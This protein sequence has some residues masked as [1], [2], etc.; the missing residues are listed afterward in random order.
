MSD[1]PS[2]WATVKAVAAAP[3]PGSTALRAGIGAGAATLEAGSDSVSALVAAYQQ[4]VGGVRV[5][6]AEQRDWVAMLTSLENLKD[7]ACAL[8]AEL[9]V[10]VVNSEVASAHLAAKDAV[11]VDA[12]AEVRA[13]ARERRAARA[14]RSAINQVALARRES[15]HRAAILVGAARA[16]VEEMPHTLAALGSGRLNEH[17]AVLLVRETACLDRAGRAHVDQVLCADPRA[18]AGLGAKRLLALAA[19]HAYALDPASVVRRNERAETERN[20]TLRPAPGGMTYLSALLPLAQ[21]VAVLANLRGTAQ[22]AR[23][24]GDERSIGQVMADTLVERTTG[25]A[26]A[27]AV[28][29]AVNLIVS[30]ATLLGAGHEPAVLD[31]ALHLP[32]QLARELVARA[33]Q[34]DTDD[35]TCAPADRRQRAARLGAWVRRLYADPGGNLVA[36]DSR[37]RTFPTALAALLRVRDQGLCRTPF[38]D[39]PIAH[40]DHVTPAAA[41]GATSASNGQGLCAGCNYAKQAPG[42]DQRVAPRAERHSVVTTTPTGHTYV[43]TA[44]AVPTPLRPVARRPDHESGSP[45]EETFRAIIEISYC[46]PTPL[47]TGPPTARTGAPAAHTG[48]PAAHTGP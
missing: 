30:D 27:S 48:P 10:R 18:L 43:S 36:M 35:A 45:V 40:T 7:A 26:A 12:P 42:W 20:V 25:Q 38:C 17:R 14:R 24:V 39:A 3:S 28:P 1:S 47:A 41:V 8:Q 4:I 33:M 2:P 9:A 32:S 21:G 15:P 23:A 34:T 13:A 6:G 46:A 31:G 5:E 11:D 19:K 37:T 44:P 16:L 22:T 29:V